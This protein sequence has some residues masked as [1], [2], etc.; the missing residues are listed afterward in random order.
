LR[1]P[2][3]LVPKET[4]CAVSNPVKAIA[5]APDWLA[6]HPPL[7][8]NLQSSTAAVGEGSGVEVQA[9][10]WVRVVILVVVNRI[11]R[12]ESSNKRVREVGVTIEGF[13]TVY[14]NCSLPWPM[15]LLRGKAG[16]QPPLKD[17]K[18]VAGQRNR[19]NESCLVRFAI[20][21]NE[22]LF[23]FFLMMG[24]PRCHRTGS[25]CK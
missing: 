19:R 13:G 10:T 3:G 16:L 24:P 22:Y 21:E 8:W 1:C 14:R 20:G 17:A 6:A 15:G 2:A 11:S 9:T 18:G 5:E 7:F 4:A 12:V 25:R 23:F